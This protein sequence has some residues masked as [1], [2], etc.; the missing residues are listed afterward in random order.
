MCS[1]GSDARGGRLCLEE[2]ATKVR[3]HWNTLHV[4]AL[5]CSGLRRSFQRYYTLFRNNTFLSGNLCLYV[6]VGDEGFPLKCVYE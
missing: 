4:F 5:I 2:H 1:G 3:S 6:F